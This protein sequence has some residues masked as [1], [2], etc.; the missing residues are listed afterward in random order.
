MDTGVLVVWKAAHTAARRLRASRED[1][2]DVAQ[3][4]VLRFLERSER[5]ENPADWGTVVGRRE[6][7]YRAREKRRSTF[8]EDRHGA[9]E[10]GFEVEIHRFK[11]LATALRGASV[12]DRRIVEAG[13]AGM[14]HAEI[15]QEIGLPV[16]AVG[17]YLRR[18]ANRLARSISPQNR[19]VC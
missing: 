5:V 11:D 18:A 4:A 6:M 3:V 2:E 13:L 19:A 16:S 14:S 1:A 12:A 9:I 15:A 10:T 8:L 7:A 17:A